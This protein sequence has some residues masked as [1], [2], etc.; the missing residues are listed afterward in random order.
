MRQAFF[1]GM[2]ALTLCGFLFGSGPAWGWNDRTHMAV[3]KAAGYDKWYNSAGPDITK[4]KA[5]GKEKG[6]HYCNNNGATKVDAVDAALVMKQV[7]LYNN[8]IDDEGHL[9]GAIIASLRNYLKR[10]K[11]HKSKKY[12]GYHLVFCAHY[13]GDLSMPFHNVCYGKSEGPVGALNA[14][15]HAVNDGI[16]ENRKNKDWYQDVIRIEAKIKEKM[17]KYRVTI[18][19]EED[20]SQNI[21]GLANKSRALAYKMAQETSVDGRKGRDLTE[22]EAYEQLAQSAALLQAVLQYAEGGIAKAKSK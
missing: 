10:N 7:K 8:C 1:K 6:N 16:V 17:P 3:S 20:F 13:L 5:R 14:R 15:R 22:E 12:A 18:K 11:S 4:L 21:A 2:A 9:Y 19:S